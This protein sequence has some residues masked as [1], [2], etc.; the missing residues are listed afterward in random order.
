MAAGIEKRGKAATIRES[1]GKSTTLCRARKP[2]PGYNARVYRAPV[3]QL[4]RALGFEPR[5][6]RFESFRARQ[7]PLTT[8]STDLARRGLR[9]Q[10]NLRGGWVAYAPRHRRRC[11]PWSNPSGRANSLSR[12]RVPIQLGAVSE[13]RRTS[14]EVGSLALPATAGDA[15]RG[16]ILPGAPISCHDSEYR[17]SSA[18][19]QSSDEPPWRLGR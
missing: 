15:V 6:R 10:T 8:V 14:V 13:F 4:D 11:R 9:V 17:F 2:H 3:A 19:S 16:R 12:Q 5:G 7:F 18:R 1:R